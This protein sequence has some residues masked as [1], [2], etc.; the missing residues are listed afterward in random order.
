MQ[1]KRSGYAQV[2]RGVWALGLVSL[3]MDISSE[4]IH[5]LLPIFLMTGLGASASLVGLIEGIGEAT[6]SIVKIFSGYLSDL[7]GKRKLLALI[8]YGLAA[9]TKP[10]FAIAMTPYEV[11]GARFVDRVGKG[12]RGA[13]RDAL[14]ADLTPASVRGAAFGIRQAMDTIG[15]FVGPGLA[16]A[17][18][19]L[20]SDDMRA[21]FSWAIV[22]GL[23]SV[24]L[25]FF[26]VEDV[27]EG[28]DKPK[29]RIPINLRSAANLGAAFWIVTA[30]GAV[31]SLAKF[32][33]AFLVL[34]A[35]NVGLSIALVP[36]VMIA[37]NMI[38]AA[39][40]AP[41]G[42]LSDRIGRYGLL[43]IGLALLIAADLV[44]GLWSS[45]LGVFAGAA[46]W[47]V[48]L[49]FTQGVLSALVADTAP[50]HLRG[51]AFGMFNLIGG[52]ATLLASAVAGALWEAIGPEATFLTGAAFAGV[53]LAGLTIYQRR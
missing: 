20:Y 10:V 39:V 47:G 51:T 25:L 24:V 5:A 11:L 42:E 31:F 4:M 48:H 29:A 17:L 26:G 14:I 35:Q 3:F 30:I 8:G 13:P 49:G 22:P 36:L 7:L 53:A 15:A 38:Y 37:M 16:I 19:W 12:I 40:S 2:P 18:M 34:R 46:L 41:I 1:Q 28:R 33:E 9:L 32:S 44:L 27:G 23:I 45:V 52:V 50:E 43:G 21:V 6:A